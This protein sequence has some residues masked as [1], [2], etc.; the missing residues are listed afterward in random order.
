[1]TKIVFFLPGLHGGGAEKVAINLLRKLDENLFEIHLI[2]TQKV[3]EYI[4]LIPNY[5]IVHDLEV[6]KTMLSI[7]NLR[8]NILK[9]KPDIVFSTLI[10]AHIAM[11]LALTGLK[12]KPKTIYRSPNSPKLLI[13]NNQLSFI[14]TIL[15]TRAYRNAD[16]IISQTPEMKDEIVKYHS[17]D[18]NKIEVFLNPVDCKLIDEKIKN[19]EN[20]FDSSF[21]NIVAAGRLTEQKGFD[22]LIKSFAKVLKLNDSCRLFIIGNEDSNGTKGKLLELVDNLNLKEKVF[23]LRFQENPYK[24]FYYSDLYVLSSRWEGLP[25]TVLENLYL[26]K[27]IVATRC[28]PFMDTLIENGKNGLLVNVEDEDSLAEAILEYKII[29]TDYITINFDSSMINNIFTIQ[30]REVYY[31]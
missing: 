1:M 31:V 15:L 6:R 24:Y 7:F 2:L 11:D 29:N 18:I 14:E 12:N 5:V 13:E 30:K 8:K 25:N 10:R 23:F 17:I 3:G 26:K 19:I 16:T 9:I 27:P 22:V 21:I 4:E 28:I 20:P